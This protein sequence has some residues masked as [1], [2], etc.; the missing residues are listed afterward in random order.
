[1][2]LGLFPVVSSYPGLYRLGPKGA[3]NQKGVGPTGGLGGG[4]AS[5][6]RLN[7]FLQP[8]SLPHLVSLGGVYSEAFGKGA[9]QEEGVQSSPKAPRNVS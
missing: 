6:S 3:L 5:M 2:S 8:L 9:R 4:Q 7:D 1:M